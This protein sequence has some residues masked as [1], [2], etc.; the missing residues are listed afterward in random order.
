MSVLPLFLLCQ[1]SQFVRVCPMIPDCFITCSLFN[2]IT[3][4]YW[5]LKRIHVNQDV[6]S[7][8][9][10][11]K[12]S[13]AKFRLFLSIIYTVAYLQ[14]GGMKLF[15]YQ[16]TSTY[17]IYSCVSKPLYRVAEG[18]HLQHEGT[19]LHHQVHGQTQELPVLGFRESVGQER[20]W[21]RAQIS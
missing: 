8:N 20:L 11:Q 17:S 6:V 16:C 13:C 19:S 2:T 10:W 15:A 18:H 21:E 12:F 3:R 14:G 7:G 5:L 9:E 1:L 4:S